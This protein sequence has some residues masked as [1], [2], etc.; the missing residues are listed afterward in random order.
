MTERL[1][2]AKQPAGETSPGG[3]R[4]E[5]HAARFERVLDLLACPACLGTLRVD[6]R[7]PGEEVKALVCRGCGRAYPVEDGIPILLVDRAT[8]D[9]ATLG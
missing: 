7:S 4:G 1:G 2:S 3:S 6:S 9:R 5:A 8:L